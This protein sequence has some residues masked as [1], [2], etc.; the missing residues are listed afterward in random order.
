M[1]IEYIDMDD[2]FNP[3]SSATPAA[4]SPSTV[5]YDDLGNSDAS[6]ARTTARLNLQTRLAGAEQAQKQTALNQWRIKNGPSLIKA[7]QQHLQNAMSFYN[8]QSNLAAQNK[9]NFT[10]GQF[11]GTAAKNTQQWHQRLGQLKQN[12]LAVHGIS[13]IDPANPELNPD[14]ANWSAAHF[15]N[16]VLPTMTPSPA[17]SALKAQLAPLMPGAQQAEQSQQQAALAQIPTLSNQKELAEIHKLNA[18]SGGIKA[19]TGYTNEETEQMPLVNAAKNFLNIS[20]GNAAIITANAAKSRVSIEQGLALSKEMLEKAEG[21]KDEAQARRFNQNMQLAAKM[22]PLHQ[23]YMATKA[24]SIANGK[25]GGPFNAKLGRWFAGFAAAALGKPTAG[26]SNT[27]NSEGQSGA[28]QD[29]AAAA[30]AAAAKAKAKAAKT[31][32][33]AALND[34]TPE[35]YQ[36]A[37]TFAH[38]ANLPAPDV[39]RANRPL[40]D[41]LI[42]AHRALQTA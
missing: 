3:L 36:R 19:K 7:Y 30:A 28:Q 22:A 35:E 6:D 37:F 40:Y 10:G 31:T 33:P 12:L 15:H 42:H 26:V 29:A 5:A 27:M 11:D 32:Q 2:I 24:W 41:Q 23:A 8:N 18:Q 17:V 4:A 14:F 13:K 34:A 39:M 9:A 21:T 16:T 38:G 25:L 1:G 20:R